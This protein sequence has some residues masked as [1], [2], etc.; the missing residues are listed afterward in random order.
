[1]SINLPYKIKNT[2]NAMYNRGHRGHL[3][4]RL[5]VMYVT[6]HVS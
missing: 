6:N 1:M 3:C 4:H 5:E 2:G